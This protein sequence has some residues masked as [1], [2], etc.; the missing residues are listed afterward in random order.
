MYECIFNFSQRLYSKTHKKE[1]QP[2]MF[3]VVLKLI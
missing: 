2:T 1:V 3:E